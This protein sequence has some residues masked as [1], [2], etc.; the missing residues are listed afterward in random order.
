[1][2]HPCLQ[3]VFQCVLGTKLKCND[4]NPHFTTIKNT[5]SGITNYLQVDM[6][7]DSS[8]VRNVAFSF[9]Q[10]EYSTTSQ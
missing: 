2:L 3:R 4:G 5:T 7:I 1:M 6:K 10:I 9:A 8:D